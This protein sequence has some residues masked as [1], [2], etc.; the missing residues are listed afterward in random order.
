MNC[1][2][3]PRRSMS[4]VSAGVFLKFNDSDSEGDRPSSTCGF[5]VHAPDTSLA[6]VWTSCCIAML[7]DL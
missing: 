6:L 4:V 5:W 2:D 3:L 7:G 1:W